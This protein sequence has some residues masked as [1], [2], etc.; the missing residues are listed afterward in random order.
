[1]QK[2]HIQNQ[3][4][5]PPQFP[6]LPSSIPLYYPQTAAQ[7]LPQM[8]HTIVGSAQMAHQIVSNA[9]MAQPLGGAPMRCFA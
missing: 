5:P 8:A 2:Q 3:Q 9:Q 6:S 7:S 4:R 1:M